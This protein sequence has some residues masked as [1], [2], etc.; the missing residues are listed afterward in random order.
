MVTVMKRKLLIPLL[1]VITI[2]ILTL[3]LY[4]IFHKK[5]DPNTLF[6]Y[7]N[8]D[9]RQVDIGFRV[10]GQVRE[11]FFEEGDFVREGILLCRLDPSPY[12]SQL[13]E[14]IATAEAVRVNL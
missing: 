14:A 11:L 6:L 4:L 7:G 12:D 5:K 3:L 1:A 9:V 10:A 8:V 2:T 13:Q